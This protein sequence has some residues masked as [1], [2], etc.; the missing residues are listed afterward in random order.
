MF[1]EQQKSAKPQKTG[2]LSSPVKL[3]ACIFFSLTI[4]TSAVLS[5]SAQASTLI[6]PIRDAETETLIKDYAV[7]IFRAAQVGSQNIKIH[8]IR[9]LNFNAFVIDGRNMFIHAG[10]L[11]KTQTPNQLIGIIAHETGHIAGGHLAGL[12]RQISKTRGP[13]LLCQVLAIM[14]AAAA[15]TSGEKSLGGAGL[16]PLGVCGRLIQRSILSYRRAHESAADQA[17]LS[18]L[19][20]TKQSGRGMLET[21]EVFA[22]Q[23]LA[24]ARYIDPYVQSHPLA[25]QRIT[26][27]RTLARRSPYYKNKD[28]RSLQFR[29]DMMRAKIIGFMQRPQAVLNK[30]RDSDQSLPAQYARA[31]AYYRSGDLKRSIKALD[32]MLKVLPNNAYLHE[33]RGQFLFEKGFSTQAIPS[34]RKALRLAPKEDLIRILLAEVLLATDNRKYADE[35]IALLR[36]ALVFESTNSTAYRLLARAYGIKGKISHARLAS[37]HRY[38]Y[39][40]NLKGAREQAKWAQRNLKRGSAA[41]LQADD[42]L[43]YR[44]PS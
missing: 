16:A 4:L 24:S 15:V 43:S 7:P 30:F 8:I 40:G 38:F 1:Q 11:M 44:P 32:R 2:F 36:K 27:L 26:Q 21:F 20:A 34:L 19:N 18:Y 37:A 13:A 6:Y 29:H 23:A 10:A 3:A 22:D 39:E 31:I 42:I 35:S 33:A 12:R 28:P 25:R 41:W 17:A 14:T 5:R 9:D